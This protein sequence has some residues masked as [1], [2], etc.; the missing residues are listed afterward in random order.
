MSSS[1]SFR[2]QPGE[3]WATD[4]RRPS[5]VMS[6]PRSS[7]IAT[8]STCIGASLWWP[9]R[10]AIAP[11]S[12]TRGIFPAEPS[13]H[14]QVFG[15]CRRSTVRNCSVFSGV[16]TTVSRPN[17]VGRA[18]PCAYRAQRL[19][20]GAALAIETR[21][22]SPATWKPLRSMRTLTPSAGRLASGASGLGAPRASARATFVKLSDWRVAWTVTIPVAART[23]A[24]KP[25]TV[26]CR[27]DDRPR[28]CER[29]DS[30]AGRR[31]WKLAIS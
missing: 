23:Q 14:C 16:T 26:V 10:K 29:A 12:P 20:L 22:C 19:L 3:P 6:L 18:A 13:C 31:S 30:L 17:E 8:G 11:S 5:G 28:F 27:T 9:P 4:Q 15:P 25:R 1:R 21:P 24:S 7:R 2:T